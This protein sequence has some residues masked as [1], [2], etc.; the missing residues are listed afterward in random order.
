MSVK[1]RFFE[2]ALWLTVVTLLL[3]VVYQ[4]VYI[5]W[6]EAPPAT[7]ILY[8]F[9]IPYL[10]NLAVYLVILKGMTFEPQY[11]VQIIILSI[12]VKL[13]LFGAFNFVMIYFSPGNAVPNVVA[14]F[15]IYLTS[16]MLEIGML[17]PL[18][19]KHQNAKSEGTKPD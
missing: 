17:V 19:G 13:L 14:F 5:L 6:P 11:F 12:V 1:K 4:G 8:I 16:T 18:I 2:F 10:L 15:V 3:L 7:Y 9:L